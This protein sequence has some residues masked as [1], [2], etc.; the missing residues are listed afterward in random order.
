MRHHVEK[1]FKK[2]GYKQNPLDKTVFLWFED[3]GEEDQLQAIV[4]VFVDDIRVYM[5]AWFEHNKF[6]Q[7][8]GM[9]RFR[10]WSFDNYK[11]VGGHYSHSPGE[12]STFS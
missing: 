3:L 1:D 12:V 10:F 7:L 9:Y 11:D 6:A 4:L 5:T 8:Q 2:A